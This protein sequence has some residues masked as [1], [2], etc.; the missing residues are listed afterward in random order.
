MTVAYCWANKVQVELMA[1]K[2]HVSPLFR[3]THV[4][5]AGRHREG[6]FHVGV[7]TFGLVFPPT[8]V[9]H[10]CSGEYRRAQTNA[11]TLQ[12][13]WLYHAWLAAT[14]SSYFNAA[15]FP[16]F[17]NVWFSCFLLITL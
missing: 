1:H 9:R 3:C 11:G 8:N 17:Y 16:T 10:Q 14:H 4:P 6:P 2:L 7:Q 5:H 15:F 13:L 12:L